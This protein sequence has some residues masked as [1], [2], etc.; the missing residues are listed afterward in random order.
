MKITERFTRMAPDEL[1]YEIYVDDPKTYTKPFTFQL[2]LISPAGFKLLPYDC[3]EG[4]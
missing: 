1:K 4:N 3:H 2:P